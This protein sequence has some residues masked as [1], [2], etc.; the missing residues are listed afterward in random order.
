VAVSAGTHS[1]ARPA[2]ISR[3]V[4]PQALSLN[5]AIVRPKQLPALARDIPVE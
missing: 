2:V 3:N 1:L 4:C 5:I